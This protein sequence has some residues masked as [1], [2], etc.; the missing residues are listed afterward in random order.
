[1]FEL[2]INHFAN[3]CFVKWQKWFLGKIWKEKQILRHNI[4]SMEFG[5][6]KCNNVCSCGSRLINV[7]PKTVPRKKNKNILNI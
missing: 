5:R 7:K 1:M 2:K 4:M 3:A 6:L